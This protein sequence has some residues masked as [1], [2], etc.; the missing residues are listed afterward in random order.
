MARRFRT[1]CLGV[2]LAMLGGCGGGGGETDR[3]SNCDID[4]VL[5]A[6]DA[7]A[8]PADRIDLSHWSLTIPVD[9]NG[10]TTG[11]A[12]TI[13]PATLTAG[14]ESEWFYATDDG[15][16]A[17]WAPV[18]GAK[19]PNS[20]YARSEL[21]ELIDPNDQTVNWTIGGNAQMSARVAVSQVQAANR[22]VIVG[23]IVAHS[24]AEEDLTALLHV[25]YFMHGDTCRASLY[26][27]LSDG[28]AKGSPVQQL[29]LITDALRLNDEFSFTIRVNN[30]VLTLTSGSQTVTA[31]INAAWA[32]TPVYFRAGA[33]LNSTGT[34]VSDGAS[35]TFYELAVTH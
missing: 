23:K 3:R 29:T 19:T 1:T 20:Q 33:G 2:L 14:Y 13:S 27:L 6:N 25:V 9:A 22:K 15:G 32:S 28:P 34:N 21:R 18:T 12:R 35:V 8:E 31:N 10:G 7:A 11:Q 16:V 5:P 30:G 26:G 17:L 4:A 24:S